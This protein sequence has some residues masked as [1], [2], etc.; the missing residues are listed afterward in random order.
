MC[1]SWTPSDKISWIR[2][3]CARWYQNSKR[4][5]TCTYFQFSAPKIHFPTPIPPLYLTGKSF[6]LTSFVCS[7]QSQ[8]L[9]HARVQIGWDWGPESTRK[10]QRVSSFLSRNTGLD[11]ILSVPASI[12]CR[13]IIGSG[14][15]IIGPPVKRHFIASLM[16]QWWPALITEYRFS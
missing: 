6:I 16:G 4:V 2:A 9:Q 12:P 1:Q 8:W 10:P 11:T 15:V 14:R 5:T 7:R 13:V 3:W